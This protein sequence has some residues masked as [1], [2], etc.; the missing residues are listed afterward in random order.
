MKKLLKFT[1]LFYMGLFVLLFSSCG[2]K[3]MMESFVREGV[4]P[5]YIKRV[6]VLKFENNSQ[7]SYA[8]ERLRN[9]TMTQILSLGLFD[10]IDKAMVDVVLEEQ[11]L[12]DKVSLDKSTLRRIAKKLGVQALV[13]GSVDAYEEKREGSYTYPVIALTL[14]LID[15][16]SGEVIWQAS[17]TAS[18][19]STVGR[20]FGLRPQD[21]TQVSFNLVERLL[22]TLK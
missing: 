13:V 5:S 18:G 10:V 14:R 9:I 8:A 11:M 17:G 7:D 2:S 4:D 3:Q 19:Y 15:G 16:A 6:A 20:L 1:V 22:K 12:G 21:F